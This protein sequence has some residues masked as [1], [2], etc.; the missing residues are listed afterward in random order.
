MP[1]AQDKGEM[2]LDCY[3]SVIAIYNRMG[4][5]DMAKMFIEKRDALK[6][7]KEKVLSA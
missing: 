1:E 6:A 5:P 7:E 3:E 2:L 4:Q